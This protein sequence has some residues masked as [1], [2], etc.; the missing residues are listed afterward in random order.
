M[1]YKGMHLGC[2]GRILPQCSSSLQLLQLLQLLPQLRSPWGR[3]VPKHQ[4][5]GLAGCSMTE[6]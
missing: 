6:A 1:M 2:P 4:Q 3:P 5:H